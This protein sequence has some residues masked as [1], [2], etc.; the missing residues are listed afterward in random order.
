MACNYSFM[1]IR[2]R[3]VYETEKKA[4]SLCHMGVNRDFRNLCSPKEN[5]HVNEL[6][7]HTIYLKKLNKS[8]FGLYL[9]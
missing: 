4:A 5:C 9:K 3:L 6:K 1:N 2:G 8:K 7:Y